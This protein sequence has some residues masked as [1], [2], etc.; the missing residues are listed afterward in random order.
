M[1]EISKD[2]EDVPPTKARNRRGRW[3]I[4]DNCADEL[5][6]IEA[7][8]G[9]FPRD[10]ELFS[11]GHGGLRDALRAHHGGYNVSRARY[12]A[13]GIYA[14]D[15]PWKS[16][17]RVHEDLRRIQRTLGRF[18]TWKDLSDL[19]ESGMRNAIQKYH[20]G[21]NAVR[22]S[23]NVGVAHHS[24]GHW[25]AWENVES[26]VRALI[27]LVGKFPVCS[28]FE[29]HARLDLYL[30][31]RKH[32]GGLTAVRERMGFRQTRQPYGYWKEW[33]NV[34]VQLLEIIASL[35]RFPLQDEIKGD[36]PSLGYAIQHYHGGLT[37]VRDRLGYGPVTDETLAS[38]ADA[39]TA[40]VP[41]LGRNPAD[42]WSRMKRSWTTRD[43][44]AAVA[45]HATDGS[46]DAFRRL[47]DAPEIPSRD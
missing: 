37:A 42:L 7:E 34:R 46:L 44:G 12:G 14:K 40:I 47:L 10:R 6:R 11:L 30:G 43:L 45:A 19:K 9:H 36:T 29:A 4:W 3:Q 33:E 38:H 2:G 28:D 39:L 5:R 26:N 13:D 15:T 21:I 27:S 18:P 24:R 8:I 17:D 20:G 32:H 35:G 23:M 31:I 41:E 16:V 22:R 25:H 1:I